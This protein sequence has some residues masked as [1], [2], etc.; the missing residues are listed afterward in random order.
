MAIVYRIVQDHRGEVKVDSQPG[1]G[2]T[3]TVEL[4][5]AG[6]GRSIGPAGGP[7]VAEAMP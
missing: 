4:P 6:G 5:V 2:T 3:I 1:A 7:E